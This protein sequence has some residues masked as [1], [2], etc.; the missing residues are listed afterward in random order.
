MSSTLIHGDCLDELA[1][2]PD[3]SV[4]L[5]ATDL[6]YGTTACAWDTPIDLREMW[7]E[8]ERVLVPHGTFISTASQ[9]FTTALA[10]S[11]LPLLRY[12]LV[13]E[14]SRST[15]F[16]HAQRKPLK[17]HEDILV[18]SKGKAAAGCQIKNRMT[19]NPQGLVELDEPRTSRNRLRVDGFMRCPKTKKDGPPYEVVDN[20]VF[21][22]DRKQTHTNYPTSVLRFE[23]EHHPVHRTQKPLALYEYL[24]RT[25]SNAGDVVVDPTM[26]SC[27]TG[28][29]CVNVGDR[30][31]I[32]VE[33]DA[34][35]FKIA[36]DR[37]QNLVDEMI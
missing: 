14:K 35:I 32:G 30:T 24:I 23:S 27:T 16:V 18:F 1:K 33:K 5:I 36:Q 9:P 17:K 6:P 8:V 4:H 15:G 13:W 10:A 31:F 2:L 21:K 11:N 25:Y 20:K 26:G 3:Q 7:R 19:Y 34:D 29:A 12:A 37:I 22:S 28:V